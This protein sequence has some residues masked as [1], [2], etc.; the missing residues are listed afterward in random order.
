MDNQYLYQHLTVTVTQLFVLRRY[1]QT[2]DASQNNHQAAF[3]CPCADWYTKCFQP[4]MTAAASD[5]SVACS[6]LAVR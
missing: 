5:V 3:R 2:Q 6:M 1:W 4:A